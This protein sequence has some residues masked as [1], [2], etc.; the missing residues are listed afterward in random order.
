MFYVFLLDLITFFLESIVITV[1]V[2]VVDM[3]GVVA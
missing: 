1:V 3:L 2:V